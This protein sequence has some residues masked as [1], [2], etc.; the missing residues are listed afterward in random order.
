M[1]GEDLA[2]TGEL[3]A[4]NVGARSVISLRAVVLLNVTVDPTILPGIAAPIGSLALLS[5]S[6][7]WQKT[8]AGATAWTLLGGGSGTVGPGTV[9]HLSK[10]TAANAV[11]D[12]QITDNG[13]D[14]DVHAAGA[15]SLT[16]ATGAELIGAAGL[17]LQGGNNT[18]LGAANALVANAGTTIDV[19][20]GSDLQLAAGGD[21]IQGAAGILNASAFGMSFVSTGVGSNIG[22]STTDGNIE[23]HSAV[24]GGP[25]N[26]VLQADNGAA[27]LLANTTI[28]VAGGGLIGVSTP[29]DVAVSGTSSVTIS[30]GGGPVDINGAGPI[31]IDSVAPIIVSNAA[32]HPVG[33]YGSAGV[34]QQ[35]GVP[36]TAAGIHAALVALG[37]ITP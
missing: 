37:L 2:L 9:N 6:G 1:Q 29:G 11:G 8:G 4:Q 32:G 5:G 18:V 23:L 19:N 28:T 27:S 25:G 35:A 13:S 14:I 21:L 3:T 24:T 26:L 31:V 16:A 7:V 36:V 22:M 34:A 10:F 30:A 33:F 12:S 17:N 20:A 15:L